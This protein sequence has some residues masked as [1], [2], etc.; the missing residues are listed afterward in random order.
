VSSNARL[1]K[2]LVLDFVGGK[3]EAE[4][5]VTIVA[6]GNITGESPDTYVI[7]VGTGSLTRNSVGA[8]DTEFPVGTAAQYLPVLINNSGTSDNFAVKA[9]SS[10]TPPSCLTAAPN[11]SSN[12]IQAAWDIA[13]AAA[14]GSNCTITLDYQDVALR[15]STYDPNTAKVVRCLGTWAT[16]ALGGPDVGTSVT[17]SGFTQ[18][19]PFGIGSATV[20]PLELA[21]FSGQARPSSNLLRWQTLTERNTDRFEVE[22]GSDAQRFSAIGTVQAA[23]TSYALHD[24]RFDDAAPLRGKNYYRLKI[25]DLDGSVAYSPVISLECQSCSVHAPRLYPVP[26]GGAVFL[27]FG[28]NARSEDAWSLTLSDP[29]GRLLRSL[30]LADPAPEGGWPLDLSAEKPGVYFFT[31]TNGTERWVMRAVRE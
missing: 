3:L 28:K 22:R 19:S 11:V 25:M 5:I 30:T 18:F 29:T 21:D 31:L 24:Y 20:L 9:T 13:E 10:T 4:S 1:P 27:A 8:T 6:G 17:G 15:G 16:H 7:T 26:T 2:I 14:G 23:G 12:A